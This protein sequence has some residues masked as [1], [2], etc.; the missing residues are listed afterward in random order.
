VFLIHKALQQRAAEG[1]PVRVAV[2]GAGYMGRGIAYQILT[3]VPGMILAAVCNRTVAD[4]ERA[5]RQAGVEDLV[6]VDSTSELEAAIQKS[7]AAV[8]DDPYIICEAANIDVIIEVTG[9]IEFAAH[10]VLQAIKHGKHVVL[11][12]A[13]L[14]AT[15]GPLLKKH[16]DKAGVILTNSDGDQPGVIMN[17]FRYVEAIG[18]RPVLAGNIKGLQ[19]PYRTPTTQKGFAEKYNQKPRMV[20]SFADGSKISMEMATVANA[21]GF[22]VGKRGMFGFPCKHVNDTPDLFPRDLMLDVGLVDYVIGAEPP[23]GVFVIGYHDDSIQQQYLNYYKLGNGPFYVFYNPYHICHFEVPLTA[24]RAVL[25][26]DATIAPLGGPVVD[27]VAVAKRDLK[28]GETLDS[29]GGYTTYGVAENSDNCARERLLP[30]GLAE[31]CRLKRDVAIDQVLCY[32]DVELP[33]GRLCDTLRAEQTSVF[34]LE[35]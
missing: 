34:M 22:R 35:T 19:D 18:M 26:G 9:T 31:G 27:V 4:A 17:L 13:E 21:T 7:R 11:M 12:N 1:N 10:V 33:E 14:D 15:I 3:A 23:G 25:F 2:I 16:A 32:Q 20:T 24:A 28:Q 5:Y 6:N 30:M 8:T 29:I